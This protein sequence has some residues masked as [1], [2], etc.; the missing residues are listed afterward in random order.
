MSGDVANQ[1]LSYHGSEQVFEWS[2]KEG[3]DLL[4]CVHKEQARNVRKLEMVHASTLLRM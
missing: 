3:E 2:K 1:L 4:V